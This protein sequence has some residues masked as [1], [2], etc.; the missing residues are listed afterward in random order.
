M[1]TCEKTVTCLIFHNSQGVEI[2]IGHDCVGQIWVGV[3]MPIGRHCGG[4]I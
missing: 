2:P 4:Q 1:V 3:E